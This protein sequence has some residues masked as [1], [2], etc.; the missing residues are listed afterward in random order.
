MKYPIRHFV[1]DINGRRVILYTDHEP[2]LGSWN[3]P[4][5]QSHD[6]IALNAINEIAQWT[7]DVRHK[8]RKDLVVP[9][10]LSR[11]FSV[12]GAYQVGPDRDDPDYVPPEV[13]MAALQEVS[14]NA[15]SPS[16]IAE[17]QKACPDVK[18]P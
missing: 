6:P 8:S 18:K 13:T 7:S 3:N 11:P 14:L 17:A 9:D 2:L 1:D 4:N 16:A 12:P 5:L 10:L 15:V